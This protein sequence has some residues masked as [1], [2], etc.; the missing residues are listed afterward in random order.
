VAENAARLY[1]P[2]I[3]PVLILSALSS[4][5]IMVIS[6]LSRPWL[7][8]SLLAAVSL[9]AT[10]AVSAREY[11]I[12]VHRAVKVG[13]TYTLS[14][15]G[16]C[17]TQATVTLAG[18]PPNTQEQKNEIELEGTIK[19]LAVNGQGDATKVSCIVEKCVLNDKPV[20]NQGDSIVAEN[21][22]TRAEYTV[23]G[24]KADEPTTK[25]LSI[26]MDTA[27]PESKTDDDASFG[28]EQPQKV[29]G[30]W[31]VNPEAIAPELTRRGLAAKGENV[32]GTGKLA[33]VKQVDGS[34]VLTVVVDIA[35]EGVKPDLP[36]TATLESCSVTTHMSGELP[37]DASARPLSQSMS[38]EMKMRANFT[39]EN[40]QNVAL[41][42]VYAQK[43]EKTFGAAKQ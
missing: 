32:K 6:L 36:P 3:V 19:V 1:S 9:L 10:A 38:M 27:D 26:V 20:C 16:S 37:A 17:E 24:E 18:S 28:T 31:P 25:A 29:D 13:D 34:D 21:L 2:A 23:K 22:G 39:G 11:K 35:V 12:K 5:A 33:A 30:T 4:G 43:A 40:N 41:S 8:L 14:A 15:R 7:L 42:T